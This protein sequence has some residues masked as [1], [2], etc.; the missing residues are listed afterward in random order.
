[1]TNK[2]LSDVIEFCRSLDEAVKKTDMDLEKLID[3]YNISHRPDPAIVEQLP[4]IGRKLRQLQT[5]KYKLD[6]V[7]NLRCEEEFA[8][9]EEARIA[10]DAQWNKPDISRRTKEQI[11]YCI[12]A[13][14]DSLDDYMRLPYPIEVYYHVWDGQLSHGEIDPPVDNGRNAIVTILHEWLPGSYANN[15][16]A[17][18]DAWLTAAEQMP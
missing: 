14:R 2:A 12:T 9:E 8:A 11:R 17:I 7:I 16:N 15:Y 18:R 5:A 4:R 13:L 10:K 6:T 3:D 1:M